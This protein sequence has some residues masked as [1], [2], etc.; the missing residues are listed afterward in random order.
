M[1][2]KAHT[3]TGRK[4]LAARCSKRDDRTRWSRD[5]TSVAASVH[6]LGSMHKVP[7]KMFGMALTRHLAAHVALPHRPPWPFHFPSS[8][9]SALMRMHRVTPGCTR[10]VQPTSLSSTSAP[11]DTAS[12]FA[13]NTESA[14]TFCCG[15]RTPL[16]NRALYGPKRGWN[17]CAVLCLSPVLLLA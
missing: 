7:C 16:L 5:H 17:T 12:R 8:Y 15:K 11:R 1:G 2:H 9:L 6:L 13:R 10:C 3:C 4:R 14:S